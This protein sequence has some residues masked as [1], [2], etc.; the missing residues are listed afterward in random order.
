MADTAG[1]CC[2]LAAQPVAPLL[3][4]V[5]CRGAYEPLPAFIST[6]AKD[7]V[8]KLL[9]IDP[10]RRINMWDLLKHPWVRDSMAGSSGEGE[11]G[12]AEA[13]GSRHGLGEVRAVLAPL[14]KCHV[15]SGIDFIMHV[16]LHLYELLTG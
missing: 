12:T 13:D 6:E 7:L 1:A 14:S 8:K 5:G 9:A 2:L 10:E 15:C 11:D 16:A 3:L 4:T